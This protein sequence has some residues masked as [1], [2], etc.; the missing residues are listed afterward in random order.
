MSTRNP[1]AVIFEQN[2]LT[3]AN[4]TN[5]FRKLKIVLN[6]E[7]IFYVLEKAPPKTALTDVSAEELA[8]L[9]KWWDHDLKA[10]CYMQASMNDDIQRQFEDAVHA[11]D[12]HR[13][14]KELFG[15]QSRAERYATIKE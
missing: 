12:I 15:A 4:Y 11:A 5:W 13:H 10:K 2:K 8:K 6:S 7:K 1:L 9:D 14:L 3:G